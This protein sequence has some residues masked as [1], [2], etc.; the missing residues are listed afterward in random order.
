MSQMS[1]NME[2]C[3][4]MNWVERAIKKGLDTIFALL[5]LIVLSPVF[6]L[7]YFLLKRQGDGPVLFRQ[8]RIGYKGK[9]FY[10]LKFRTMRVDSEKDGKPC[11]AKKGDDRLTPVGRF[12]REHHLDELPQLWNVFCGDMAFIGP[13]P[14]RK[15]YI[16]QI[17]E[18]DPRYRFLYQIRPGVT[19]YAT[20]YNGY[21][22]T[23]EKMLRRLRYDLF[24][25]Q[26][27]SWWF[28]FK[29]LIKTFI[30]I[31]FGKKF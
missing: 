22:D 14:E 16:D 23:I 21:T 13:R 18:H 1:V 6:L 17:M 12:L 20:L 29:I 2:I 5:G 30:C 25:L 15:F 19:S 3:D 9:P 7:V 11:L 31:V 24:Y 28:D 10:I 4:G 26:H 27:R 8:E